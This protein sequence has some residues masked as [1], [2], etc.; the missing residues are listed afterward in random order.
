M[1][2]EEA[3][4][5]NKDVHLINQIKDMFKEYMELAEEISKQPF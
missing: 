5:K 3:A 4:G 1:G 2:T